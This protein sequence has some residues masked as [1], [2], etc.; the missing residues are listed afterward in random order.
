MTDLVLQVRRVEGRELIVIGRPEEG[1]GLVVL[2]E[3]G[4]EGRQ[5]VEPAQNPVPLR[6][7]KLGLP[8]EVL[9]HQ[10]KVRREEAAAR[11][12]HGVIELCGVQLHRQGVSGG[13]H[14]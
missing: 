9:R 4:I 6:Q 5:A 10:P 11:R 12:L 3:G 1:E 14:L 2:V 7:A 8:L 13:G